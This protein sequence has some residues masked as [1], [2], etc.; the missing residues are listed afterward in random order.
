[1]TDIGSSPSEYVQELKNIFP[2]VGSVQYVIH[3]VEFQ[4]R[5]LPHA[6]VL[7]SFAQPCA[8]PADI[9]MVVSAE[10]PADPEDRK[11]VEGFMVHK[12]PTVDGE[13]TIP[14]YCLKKDKTTDCRFKYPRPL[15]PTT[16]L[17]ANGTV[18]YR[19]RNIGDEWIVP[20]NI[21]LL[22]AFNCHINVEVA[23]SSHLFAYIFKY[24]HKGLYACVVLPF[25]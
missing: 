20:H 24:I 15:Q 2:S 10:L 3:C 6:H 22:R 11:L 7:I 12:H 13:Q 5:G 4:R 17:E 19:R 23:D 21:Q 18:Q 25:T 8:S 1:M 14:N 16:F 9:D